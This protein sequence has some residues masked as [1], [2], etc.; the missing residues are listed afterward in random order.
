MLVPHVMGG[1][2]A[3][4]ITVVL[5]LAKQKASM[6]TTW[7]MRGAT[8]GFVYVPMCDPNAVEKKLWL[9]WSVE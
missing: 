7:R 3:V 6:A 4:V 9:A 2:A 1:S 8:A 5:Y